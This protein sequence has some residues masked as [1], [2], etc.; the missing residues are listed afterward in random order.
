MN[1]IHTKQSN[2]TYATKCRRCGKIHEWWWGMS[3]AKLRVYI[4]EHMTFP[5]LCN[6]SKCKL[7]TVHDYVSVCNY[8]EKNEGDEK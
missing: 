1:T 6:C 3:W 5:S 8:E 7:E 2:H 4:I